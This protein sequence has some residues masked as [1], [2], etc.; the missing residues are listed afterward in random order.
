M[1]RV[2]ILAGTFDPITNGHLDIIGRSVRHLCDTLIIAIGINPA[3]KPLLSLEDRIR[4]IQFG[5]NIKLGRYDEFQIISFEGLIVDAAKKH[6]ANILIRGVRNVTDFE[7]EMNLAQINSMLAPDIQTIFLPTKPELASVS[8]SMVKE[9]A[10]FGAD[11]SK[12]VPDVVAKE[13]YKVLN[14]PKEI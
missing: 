10:R 8:S 3:K 14:P 12:Y 13:V 7:Y 5:L 4:C 9:L 1:E 11:I 6:G 2:A